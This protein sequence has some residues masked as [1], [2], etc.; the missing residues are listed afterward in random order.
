MVS[1]EFS[2]IDLKCES[3]NRT[4][5]TPL[6]R[7][8]GQSTTTI[9][10][11]R[12]Y[13]E[14]IGFVSSPPK[15][16]KSITWGGFSQQTSVTWSDGLPSSGA[17]YEWDGTGTID[18]LGHQVSN[19]T[20]NFFSMCPTATQWPVVNSIPNFGLGVLKG[21]CWTLDPNSCSSC[22]TPFPPAGNVATNNPALDGSD[23]INAGLI[24]V[25]STFAQKASG[26]G[27]VIS[28]LSSSVN[29][30]PIAEVNSIF[31]HWVIVS[32]STDYFSTLSDEYTDAIALANALVYTSNGLVAESR[33]RTTGFI[34]T[35]TTVNYTVRCTNLLDGE[36]Y[37]A[38][39]YL[40]SD[41]GAVTTIPYAFTS[42]GTTHDIT[43]SVPTPSNG[44]STVVRGATIAYAA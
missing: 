8:I 3:A 27:A 36:D 41:D 28:L 43:G 5:F 12:G 1:L 13:N 31:G 35:W 6:V 17:R 40:R 14:W 2:V 34:S 15:K 16:Y 21:Y 33:P 4:F 20:K 9:A 25:S 30:F 29:N 11:V 10:T 42:V 23:L 26:Q 37:V 18:N 39:V 7:V 44:H 24:P 38:V 19:Y 32:S 22:P